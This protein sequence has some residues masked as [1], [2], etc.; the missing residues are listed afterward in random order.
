MGRDGRP[1]LRARAGQISTKT[2]RTIADGQ[3]VEGSRPA[4]EQPVPPPCQLAPGQPP[5]TLT[6]CRDQGR[7]SSLSRPAGR[8][9][10]RG[11]GPHL[12]RPCGTARL[13]PRCAQTPDDALTGGRS[14]SP[15]SLL[16]P[17][18]DRPDSLV[19]L[20]ETYALVI[21]TNVGISPAVRVRWS[22][23]LRPLRSSSRRR[24]GSCHSFGFVGL[25]T[26]VE[27]YSLVIPMNV[28]ISP[29]VRLHPRSRRA[30]M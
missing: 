12:S 30:A 16:S 22:S 3:L 25:S 29:I 18:E 4:H 11:A 10:R 5:P 26:R 9:C 7:W 24:S 13:A 8:A 20:V 21:P 27:T 19:G 6:A 2:P 14:A 23:V 17:V 15:L 1:V 28:G